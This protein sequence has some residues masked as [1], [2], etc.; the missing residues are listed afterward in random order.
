MRDEGGS[1]RNTLLIGIALA[2]IP[3]IGVNVLLGFNLITGTQRDVDYVAGEVLALSESRLDDAATAL[4]GVGLK[5]VGDCSRTVVDLLQKAEQRASFIAEIAVVDRSGGAICAANGQ[6][7]VVRRTSPEHDTLSLNVTLATVSIGESGVSQLIRLTWANDGPASVRVLIPGERLFPHFLKSR[8]TAAFIAQLTTVDGTAVARRSLVEDVAE[9]RSSRLPSVV[10]SAASQRYP[11]KVD[12]EVP[13]SALLR[14]NAG[15]F[16]YANIG[17]GVFAIV[18]AFGVYLFRRR[19]GGP[20]REIADGI[21]DGEFVPYYQPVIDI[22]TGKLAGCEVLVRWRR[23]NGTMIPPGRFIAL[24][25]A[26]GEIFPMTLALMEAARDELADAYARL[27]QL[28]VGFNLFAGHFD[29]SDIVDD[30]QRIFEGSPIRMNQLMFEVTERQPL[31]DIPRARL[32]IAKLQALGVRVALDDV[33]T[34]H[35]GL[36]YLLKL[37]V[38]VMKMDKM[39]VDAVGTDRYS[40]AIVDSMVKLANDMSLELIAEGVESFEQLEYLRAKGVRMA[41]G[42]VFAPPLPGAMFLQL[43]AAMNPEA[44]KKPARTPGSFGVG[45]LRMMNAR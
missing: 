24:A 41:Q 2:A 35:G 10:S 36:S 27:P 40:I 13:G 17:G 8:L 3:I 42:Y 29:D 11:F 12:I 26:S 15:L 7:R 25:E 9:E 45:P 14:A 20:V 16:F 23:R 21:R 5:D 38:D 4:I 32:V 37:G 1:W 22:T 44:M 6:P 34:G 19:M 39:F 43:V 31:N 28:K 30:V 18:V 33:G